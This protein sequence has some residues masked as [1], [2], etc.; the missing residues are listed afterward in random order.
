MAKKVTKK[1]FLKAIKFRTQSLELIKLTEAVLQNPKLVPWE[2][3]LDL[4]KKLRDDLVKKANK[5]I[6]KCERAIITDTKN[7]ISI[8]SN[9]PVPLDS[10]K[11][12]VV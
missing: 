4:A 8:R 3:Q 9:D 10:I 7:S 5:K 1:A 12:R 11:A 6:E 2:W